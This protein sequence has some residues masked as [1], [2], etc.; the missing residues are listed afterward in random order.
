MSL[1]DVWKC[2]GVHEALVLQRLAAG[3]MVPWI[4]GARGA[5]SWGVLR[6]GEWH[7]IQTGMQG[8]VCNELLEALRQ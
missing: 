6:A 7:Q 4:N 1:T 5:A 8:M 2:Q 3:A